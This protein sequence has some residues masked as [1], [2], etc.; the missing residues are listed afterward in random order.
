MSFQVRVFNKSLNEITRK[1]S[2]N[3]LNGFYEINVGAKRLIR[4]WPVNKKLTPK[5]SNH[6]SPTINGEVG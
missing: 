6:D 5:F 3:C 4:I 1:F 2:K